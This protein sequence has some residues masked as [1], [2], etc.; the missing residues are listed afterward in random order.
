MQLIYRIP[1]R[2]FF[3]HGL[4]LEVFCKVNGAS[5]VAVLGMFVA[6]RQKDDDE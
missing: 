3:R 5:N 4:V 2:K 1:P 6:A